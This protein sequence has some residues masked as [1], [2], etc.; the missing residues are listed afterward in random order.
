MPVRLMVGCLMLKRIYD[1]GDETLAEAWIMN[2]YMQYF[3]G[4][5]HFEHKFPFD[6][7]LERGKARVGGRGMEMVG[8]REQ[9]K[10]ILSENTMSKEIKEEAEINLNMSP[11]PIQPNKTKQNVH[12]QRIFTLVG[13]PSTA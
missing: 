10:Q 7:R 2:P 4:M 8:W 5:T 6:P 11:V 13:A 9:I 3:C 1:L 12:P